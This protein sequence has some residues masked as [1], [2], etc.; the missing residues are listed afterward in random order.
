MSAA[1]SQVV[2]RSP[3]EVRPEE[4]TAVPLPPGLPHSLPPASNLVELHQVA[5]VATRTQA[6][7]LPTPDALLDLGAFLLNLHRG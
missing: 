5:S 7:M 3:T 6:W 4:I 2:F 1:T